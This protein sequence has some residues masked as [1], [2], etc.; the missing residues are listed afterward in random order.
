MTHDPRQVLTRPAPPPDRTV[1]YG[2]HPDQLVDL[3]VPIPTRTF[4]EDA[5]RPFSGDARPGV[6]F[7]HGG[8]WRAAFD[9]THAGP[10]SA[11]LATRGYPV[12]TVEFRRVGTPGG[13]WPGTLDD[14]SAAVA[15]ATAE[16]GGAPV[17]MGH[18]AGGH[19]ALWYAARAPERVRAVVALAPVADLVLAHELGLGAGAVA[20]LLG[21]GPA[22]V[23][24][25]Y[26]AADP[27]RHLPLPV[28]AVLVHGT[29][30][31]RVPVEVSRRYATAAGVHLVELPGVEHFGVID[32]LSRAWPAVLE[33][34]DRVAA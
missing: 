14:V 33:A 31:D 7:I 30:D 19:L 12:A 10:L 34:L 15:A 28:P 32:P 27:M 3:R 13:G 22:D 8:F 26:A 1:R 16:L 25:R 23:P 20:A 24:D 21:G 4:P 5:S 29:E 2:D 6:I 9:R 18:S 11:D 17:L